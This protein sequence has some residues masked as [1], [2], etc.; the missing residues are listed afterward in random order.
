MKG[1]PA[2]WTNTGVRLRGLEWLPR[3]GIPHPPQNVLSKDSV[4]LIK[5]QGLEHPWNV[6]RKRVK[7]DLVNT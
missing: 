3:V 4:A 2:G 7:V 5:S 6:D 1:S